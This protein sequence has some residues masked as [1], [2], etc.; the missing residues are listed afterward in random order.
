[1]IPSTHQ[2]S[3]LNTSR[4][5]G[6]NRTRLFYETQAI[7]IY[8]QRFECA[9]WELWYFSRMST[10]L[11]FCLWWNHG[12][13]WNRD[14]GTSNDGEGYHSIL[15]YFS[16]GASKHAGN[17]QTQYTG[18]G[19]RICLKWSLKRGTFNTAINVGRKLSWNRSLGALWICTLGNFFKRRNQWGT[20]SRMINPTSPFWLTNDFSPKW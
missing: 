15:S 5:K 12:G 8:T 16:H 9:S 1:M 17:R 14:H 18:E 4:G 7:I 10:Y 13:K 11:I 20:E 6:Q 2:A 3:L 19:N